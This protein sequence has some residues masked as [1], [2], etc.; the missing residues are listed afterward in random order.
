MVPKCLDMGTLEGVKIKDRVLELCGRLKWKKFIE[1]THPVYRELKLEFYITL[2][3]LD[4]GPK[5]FNCRLNGKPISIDYDTMLAVFGFLKGGICE[6]RI[7]YKSRDFL[8]ELTSPE[9]V[10]DVR[11]S[12]NGLIKDHS[13]VIMHKFI[14]HSIFGKIE[15]NKVSKKELLM[16][17]YMHTSIKIF[18]IYFIL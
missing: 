16:L 17:W 14:C 3:F 10:L 8:R 9:E 18:T 1:M 7:R 12:L 15:S 11:G 4:Q 5:K 2:K 6:A 13:Y